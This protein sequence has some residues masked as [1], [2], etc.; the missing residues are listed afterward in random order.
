MAH[1]TNQQHHTAESHAQA[2]VSTRARFLR[3]KYFVLAVFGV[4]SVVL[5]TGLYFFNADIIALAKSTYSGDKELF[6]VPVLIALLFS[7]VHGAF[8]SKFWDV[9]GVKPKH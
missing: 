5:Y 7:F 6:F 4:M 3:H 1:N 9:L 2:S 8:T